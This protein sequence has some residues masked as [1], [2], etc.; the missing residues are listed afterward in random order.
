MIPKSLIENLKVCSVYIY[1][2]CKERE[3]VGILDSITKENIVVLEDK[4]NNKIH[5][6]LEI[7]DVIIERH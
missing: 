3:F 5:I 4:Y 6:P 2:K 1:V 7:I